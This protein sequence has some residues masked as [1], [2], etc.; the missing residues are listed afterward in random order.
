MRMSPQPFGHIIAKYWKA[1]TT[2]NHP[3]DYSVGSAADGRSS[4]EAHSN[5]R[6][7]GERSEMRRCAA[8]HAEFGHATGRL[9]RGL[10]KLGNLENSPGLD[11]RKSVGPTVLPGSCERRSGAPRSPFTEAFQKR[12]LATEQTATLP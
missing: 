9:R 3:R 11:D 12:L 7:G 4:L 5:G 1:A 8:A 2:S 10:A 6:R